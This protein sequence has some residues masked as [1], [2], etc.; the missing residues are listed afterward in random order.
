M[1]GLTESSLK[2]CWNLRA[3]VKWSEDGLERLC[4]VDPF[5]LEILTMNSESRSS[6]VTIRIVLNLKMG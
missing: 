5:M 4:E 2:R 1:I 6:G 3:A